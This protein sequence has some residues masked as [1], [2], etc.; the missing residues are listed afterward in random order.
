[1]HSLIPAAFVAWIPVSLIQAPTW[2]KAGAILGAD[3]AFVLAAVAV[4]AAGLRRYESGNRMG[5]RV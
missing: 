1:M 2:A 3:T 4:F 5:T